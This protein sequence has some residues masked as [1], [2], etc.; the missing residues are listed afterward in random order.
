LIT[1][2]LRDK[3]RDHRVLL[4]RKPFSHIMKPLSCATTL[5]EGGGAYCD[6]LVWMSWKSWNFS[7]R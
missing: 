7:Y 2:R 3:K 6:E 4:W 1:Q 5:P